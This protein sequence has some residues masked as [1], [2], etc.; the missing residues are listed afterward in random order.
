[1]NFLFSFVNV[2][3]LKQIFLN[4]LIKE[5]YIIQNYNRKSLVD[6]DL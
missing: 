1:M 4:D 6:I 5:D 3:Q 2:S